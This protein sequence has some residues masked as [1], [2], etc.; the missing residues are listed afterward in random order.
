MMF[1]VAHMMGPV[2]VQLG[3]RDVR[4]AR[5][6]PRTHQWNRLNK[7]L[8][9]EKLEFLIVIAREKN[10]R[11]AAE[12]CGVAQPT[13]S[14]AI[15]NLEDTLGAILVRRTSRFQ[16]LTPEGERVLEWARRL[17]GDARAMR[18]EVRA[19][20]R[21]LSG[22]LRIGVIPSALSYMPALTGPFR[23]LHPG[24]RITLLSRSSVE[25]VDMLADLRLEAGITYLGTETIGR[26]RSLPLYIERYRLLTTRTGPAGK[27]SQVTWAEVRDLPLCLPTSDMQNRRILD[28]MLEPGQRPNI[29]YLESDSPIALLSH[30]RQ[31][32]WATIVSERLANMV[33]G[34]ET[35]RSLPIMEPDAALQIGLV[36]PEREPMSPLLG[37]LTSVVEG[38]V[39][40]DLPND[41]T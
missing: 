3:F 35:F 15:K 19:F 5:A 2:I 13:L 37:A 39:D 23:A 41:K 34:K 20:R 22:E 7:P 17:V 16:G 31:G 32:G 28:R 25:I 24:V 30:V 33:A 26:L 29:C 12:V 4:P 18:E 40:P 21:S 10:F 11:R 14:A 1:P 38:L 8:L 36:M 27:R 6:I 9:I